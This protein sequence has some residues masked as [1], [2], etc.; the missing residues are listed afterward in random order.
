MGLGFAIC[1]SHTE[2]V[3]MPAL[4]WQNWLIWCTMLLRSGGWFC[5]RVA[6]IERGMVEVDTV[7]F[8]GASASGIF[9]LPCKPGCSKGFGGGCSAWCAMV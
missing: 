8:G 5:C 9:L 6:A 1:P 4:A 7:T 3:L 2:V